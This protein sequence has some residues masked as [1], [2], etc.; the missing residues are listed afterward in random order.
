MTLIH[1]C[2]SNFTMQNKSKNLIPKSAHSIFF[3]LLAKSKVRI[4]RRILHQQNE[5]Q[6]ETSLTTVD[7]TLKR[8]CQNTVAVLLKFIIV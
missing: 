4:L 5:L 8:T 6:F 3:K 1:L 7:R 2:C